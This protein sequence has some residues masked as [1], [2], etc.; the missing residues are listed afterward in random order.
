[1]AVNVI[2]CGLASLP[3]S[4][5]VS[6]SLSKPQ[7]EQTTDLSIPVFVQAGGGFSY[8]ADRIAYYAT[9]DGVNGDSRVTAEGRK[10]AREFFSRSDR[11]NLMAIAQVFTT[12]QAGFMRTG[13]IGSLAAFQAVTNGS[14]A[15]SI[16]GVDENISALNFS[17]DTTIAQVVA[18]IQTALTAASAGSTV[19]LSGTQLIFRSP[20]TG[21]LSQVSVLGPVSPASGTDI[22][23]VGFLNGQA[24]TAVVQPGY[25]PGDLVS[26]LDLIAEASRCSGRFVYGWV[27]DAAY[28]DS[29][30]QVAA[31][32]WA[33]SRVAAM[34]V[35]S[36][37]PTAWDPSSTTDIGPEIQTLGLYRAWPI[38]HDNVN[39]Y[40]DMSI[41]AGMLAVDYA[42]Q[43]STRT[44]KFMDL[45]GVPTVGLTVTQWLTLES[46][47]YNTFTLT[48]NTSRVTREGTTGNEAW[49]IDDL[50]NL[51][52]FTEELQVAIY[53]VFL[54]NKKVPYSVEG[55][56]MLRDAS[57]Q[58]CERYDYN[59]TLAERP[60]QDPTAQG[61]VRVDPP[62]TIIDTPLETMT[63]ADRAGRIGPPQ[64]INLNL[65]GAI[66]SLAVTVNAYS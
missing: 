16:D 37:S 18:R 32:Q 19:T 47:G 25:T 61:G 57:T 45:P 5:D 58:I 52:N 11:P 43:D 10:A 38:Y 21:D 64:T 6:I 7:A 65:A 29:N 9:A 15:V 35:V 40:P 44:A 2:N 28:R 50:V 54:R 59:G 34:P 23:G 3:R 27:L 26:E 14:F 33:Q 4:L 41:L 60:V 1:M 17:T 36:N 39:Y 62:Y 8:G 48:G 31:A 49:Y 46:K 55:Q 24:G 13:A 53:N 30:D 66:H 51:D 42:A 12:P 56:T 22:S 20:T 63:V